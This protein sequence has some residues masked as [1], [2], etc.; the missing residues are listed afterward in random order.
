MNKTINIKISLFKMKYGVIINNLDILKIYS[1]N[2]KLCT[3]I[4][5]VA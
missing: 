4:K 5:I 3:I 1:K 2:I